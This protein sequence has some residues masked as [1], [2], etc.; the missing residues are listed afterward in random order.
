M[1]GHDRR[2]VD[3]CQ[4]NG[5]SYHTSVEDR[6]GRYA[7]CAMQYCKAPMLNCHFYQAPASLYALG[8]KAK[9][10][11]LFVERDDEIH[12]QSTASAPGTQP[13]MQRTQPAFR[14]G[15]RRSRHLPRRY[16]ECCRRSS[17]S[18]LDFSPRDP[19]LQVKAALRFRGA[20]F[21]WMFAMA[22]VKRICHALSAKA[23]H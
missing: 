9:T 6:P 11:P 19:V 1:A 16:P 5:R 12:I 7:H 23:W 15:T 10:C 3:F 13:R 18:E 4:M 21:L 14:P 20:A 22:A 17:P 2:D 8:K